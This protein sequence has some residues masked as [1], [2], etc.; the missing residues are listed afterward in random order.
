MSNE[1]ELLYDDTKINNSN[2]LEYLTKIELLRDRIEIAKVR[3]ANIKSV[4]NTDY[5]RGYQNFHIVDNLNMS[6]MFNTKTLLNIYGT[7]IQHKSFNKLG[8]NKFL[9]ITHGCLEGVVN[10]LHRVE[11]IIINFKD[12]FSNYMKDATHFKDIYSLNNIAYFKEI[13][14]DRCNIL[15]VDVSYDNNKMHF[16]GFEVIYTIKLD[17]MEIKK[18]YHK[19]DSYIDKSSDELRNEFLIDYP[20]IHEYI[21]DFYP[22]FYI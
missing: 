22:E 21:N 18:G 9:Y 2:F 1:F 3:W 15:D 20:F 17:T 16:Y 13:Y 12:N 11:N 8:I 6:E 4:I 19:I 10:N 7:P 14:S 5:K